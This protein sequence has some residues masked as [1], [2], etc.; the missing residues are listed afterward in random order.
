MHRHVEGI[1]V[2]LEEVNL[3]HPHFLAFDM[4]VSWAPLNLLDASLDI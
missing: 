1:I 3:P 4:F 2:I